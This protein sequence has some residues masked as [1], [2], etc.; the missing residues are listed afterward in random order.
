MMAFYLVNTLVA[1]LIGLTLTNLIRPG[2]G[3]LLSGRRP[4]Q[5]R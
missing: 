5:P 1:M 3:A 2:I 4:A